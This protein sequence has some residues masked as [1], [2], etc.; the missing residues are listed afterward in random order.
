MEELS[1]V[2]P[3]GE[4]AQRLVRGRVQGDDVVVAAGDGGLALERPPGGQ[5]EAAEAPGEVLAATGG[6]R[7]DDEHAVPRGDQRA[8]DP[9]EAATA[10]VA[11]GPP[12]RGADP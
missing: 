3:A 7:A 6:V 9:G 4:P 8:D 2:A 12:T 10:P 1:R 11:H 5:R